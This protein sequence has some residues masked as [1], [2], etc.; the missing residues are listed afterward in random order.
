MPSAVATVE[1]VKRIMR[2]NA[3]L[4]EVRNEDLMFYIN[5]VHRALCE[6]YP[7]YRQTFSINTTLGSKSYSLHSSITSVQSVRYVY[8]T[9]EFDYTDLEPTHIE[10]LISGNP[11][12]LQAQSP[13]EPTQYYVEGLTLNIIDP[14][15]ITSATIDGEQI[16]RLDV[17]AYAFTELS[18][19]SELSALI[20]MGEVYAH[21]AM[22]RYLE[23][24][25]SSTADKGQ[26]TARLHSIQHFT[27]L[28]NQG[29]RSLA[30][31]FVGKADQ[32]APTYRPK[33][34]RFPKSV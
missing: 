15:P 4:H 34:R 16:P 20:P 28:E 3:D 31:S 25:L 18:D 6:N 32:F 14:A 8:G 12:A 24:S 9:G 27:S 33:G 1:Q 2:S 19:E 30:N 22:R 5:R 7:L 23:D 26:Y 13:C 11:D 10:D 29:L 21:G 17:D